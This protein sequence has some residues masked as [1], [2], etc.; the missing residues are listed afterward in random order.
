MDSFEKHSKTYSSQNYKYPHMQYPSNG[1]NPS[2]SQGLKNLVERGAKT[3]DN[4]PSPRGSPPRDK[5]SLI[6]T[7][8]H[9]NSDFGNL[10]YDALKK[11]SFEHSSPYYK[12]ADAK[13]GDQSLVFGQ[14][15]GRTMESINTFKSTESKLSFVSK[16]ED[17]L[18]VSVTHPFT[19]LQGRVCSLAISP[20]LVYMGCVNG[21][22]QVAH[23]SSG[24]LIEDRKWSQSNTPIEGV[25]YDFEGK[26]VYATEFNLVILD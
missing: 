6:R 16:D 18:V 20:N 2:S 11:M 10:T 24:E 12:N 25:M 13:S 22:V 15:V 4:F 14:D 7:Q 19:N 8:E 3:T 5:Q 21:D 1:Y 26:V 9:P 17:S 23:R